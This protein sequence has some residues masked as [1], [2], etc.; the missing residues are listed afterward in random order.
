MTS[1]SIPAVRREA[2]FTASDRS[3]GSAAPPAVGARR[4]LEANNACQAKNLQEEEDHS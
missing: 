1:N 4:L 2:A 3:R